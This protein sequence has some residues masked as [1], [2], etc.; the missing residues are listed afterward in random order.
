MRVV[1][2][3]R[4]VFKH[5]IWCGEVTINVCTMYVHIGFGGIF[6]F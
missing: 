4:N 6:S 5:M 1:K 3:V 2:N